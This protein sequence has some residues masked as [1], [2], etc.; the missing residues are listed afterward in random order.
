VGN[1]EVIS[2]CR[3]RRVT[4]P[5]GSIPSAS[6]SAPRHGRFHL[7]LARKLWRLT[8]PFRDRMQP[9]RA[10][11]GRRP[12]RLHRR[13]RTH[14]SNALRPAALDGD[15]GVTR[16]RRGTQPA[17]PPGCTRIRVLVADLP[18]STR[19]A[20]SV[21]KRPFADRARHYVQNIALR[22]CGRYAARGHRFRTPWPAPIGD[23]PTPS[24]RR[25]PSGRVG[26]RDHKARRAINGPGISPDHPVA[27]P[28]DLRTVRHR[29]LT[30]SRLSAVPPTR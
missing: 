19:R 5:A 1:R 26:G 25:R 12:S 7:T 9:S 22:A 13:P 4:G 17:K 29:Q 14:A 23:Y 11:S 27:T 16:R 2:S 30:G 6:K 3:A 21:L 8:L 20:R 28:A 18:R 15:H 24:P 10:A